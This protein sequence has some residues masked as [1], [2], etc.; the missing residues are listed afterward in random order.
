MDFN[1][2]T[3]EEAAKRAGKGRFPR[4]VKAAVI[5]RLIEKGLIHGKEE[6]GRWLVRADDEFERVMHLGVESFVVNRQGYSFTVVRAPIEEVARALRPR[7]GVAEYQEGVKPRKMKEDIGVQPDEKVRQAFLVQM[8]DTPEWAALIQT[9]HWFHHCD[10]VMGTALACALSRELRTSAAAAWDDDFSGSSLIVCEKG[11]RSSSLTDESGPDGWIPFHEFFYERGIY[12][13]EAFIDS[14]EGEADL[15]VANP[16]KV[17]RADRV[18]LKVPGP[19]ASK[20][21]HVFGK[22]GMLAA[23]VTSGL[24]EAGFLER[25][26]GSIWHQARAIL[27]SGEF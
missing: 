21:S 16:A 13:P 23:A 1:Y 4:R 6:E 17:Q 5:P 8:C 2:L 26:R 20:G 3:I 18:V 14:R 10:S 11:E 22:I 24:D 7:P 12:L 9:V 27:D 15:Y 25:I 19:V